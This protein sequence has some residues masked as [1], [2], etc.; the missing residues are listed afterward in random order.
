MRVPI[1]PLFTASSSLTFS[2]SCRQGD[3]FRCCLCNREVTERINAYSASTR[4]L[5]CSRR[6]IAKYLTWLKA[7]HAAQG[8][9]DSSSYWH[10]QQRGEQE[11][12]CSFGLC[13]LRTPR[14]CCEAPFFHSRSTNVTCHSD[15]FFSGGVLVDALEPLCD[16]FE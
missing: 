7:K 4:S 9:G 3:V 1:C 2:R 15:F 13:R 16:S 10:A 8:C 14:A 5:Q 11:R 12:Y 6:R